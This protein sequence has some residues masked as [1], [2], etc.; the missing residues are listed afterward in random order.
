MFP[1]THFL[2]SIIPM[3]LIFPIYKY[4]SLAFLI[5]SYLIDFDHYL[6]YVICKKDFN[7]RKAYWWCRESRQKDQMHIFHTMEFWVLMLLLSFVHIFFKL[8]F[9]GMIFHLIFDFIDYLYE[10]TSKKGHKSTRAFSFIMWLRR[11]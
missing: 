8:V 10:E 5:G 11:H 7:L 4:L 9:I 1:I 2:F 3:I 6:W